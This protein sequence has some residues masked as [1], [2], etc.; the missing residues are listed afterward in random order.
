MRG[1]IIT[2]IMVISIKYKVTLTGEGV[3]VQAYPVSYGAAVKKLGPG[4]SGT[5]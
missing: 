4:V 2:I 3:S 5:I 1:V